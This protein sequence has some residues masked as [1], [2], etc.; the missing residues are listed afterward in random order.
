MNK[1]GRTWII[2]LIILLIIVSVLI[3]LILKLPNSDSS[4][5]QP[6]NNQQSRT[7]QTTSGECNSDEDCL[8]EFGLM[9]RCVDGECCTGCGVGYAGDC[10]PGYHC[11][12][13][14]GCCAPGGP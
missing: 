5:T 14:K 3:F 8:E 6:S 9:G 10:G 1:R 13:E 7:Q 12:T 4:T 11:D 2:I